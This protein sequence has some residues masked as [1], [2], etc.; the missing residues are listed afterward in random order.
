[1]LAAIRALVST[2]ATSVC[3]LRHN[4][5]CGIR[6]SAD[7]SQIAATADDTDDG[8]DYGNARLC[9]IDCLCYVTD[10]NVTS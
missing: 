7:N 9:E 2:A 6:K 4:E 3:V 10:T 1:M 5:S 8:D